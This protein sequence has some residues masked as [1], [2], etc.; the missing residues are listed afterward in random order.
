M[1]FIYRALHLALQADQGLTFRALPRAMACVQT[2]L[3][4]FS[5][6]PMGAALSDSGSSDIGLG[7]SSSPMQTQGNDVHSNMTPAAV[8]ERLNQYI[9]GQV[10]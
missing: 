4:P 2:G 9:V 1:S 8:V 6:A 5:S 3:R 7:P 10:G